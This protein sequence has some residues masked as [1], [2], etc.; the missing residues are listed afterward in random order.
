[1][2]FIGEISFTFTSPPNIEGAVMDERA[3]PETK[4]KRLFAYLIEPGTSSASPFL[5]ERLRH[6]PAAGVLALPCLF[7]L[8]FLVT[9]RSGYIGPISIPK[10]ALINVNC[11]PATAGSVTPSDE[12]VRVGIQASDIAG[13]Y[14]FA[15]P[16]AVLRLVS[17]IAAVF[18]LF[19]IF[20]RSTASRGAATC[21]LIFA[22]SV[23]LAFVIPHSEGSRRTLVLPIA[24]AVEGASL[25]GAGLEKYI[26]ESVDLN[27][28]FGITAMM[29][30]L[31]GIA[32]IAVQA[33]NEEL[34]PV[35]LRQRLF[36]LR[37][38]M[39]LGAAV[40]VMAV[41]ITRALVDWN[42][43]FLCNGFADRLR[44]VGSALTNYWGAAASGFLLTAFLPAYLSWNGDV[45]RWAS[46]TKPEGTEKDRRLLVES[47]GLD[48]APS[49]AA[50]TLLTIAVPA[51][52]GP[53]L[54]IV[55][56]VAEKIY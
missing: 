11:L 46:I 39:L 38:S 1:V 49:T 33:R 48:F 27:S 56:G 50:T 47:E 43:A 22:F 8:I 16:S 28:W 51:L 4:I 15:I 18:G 24:R 55:K 29:V 42:L 44:P 3:L 5:R 31:C 41:V 32:V 20:Q 13:R 19:V 35:A 9:V 52:S 37:W 26:N 34:N 30:L 36:Y 53:L 6:A 45:G 54:E 40:L 10:T 21:G 25:T 17:I 7:L 14:L 12:L 23:L 2:Q